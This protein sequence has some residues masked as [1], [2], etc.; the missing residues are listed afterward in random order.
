V[1]IGEMVDTNLQTEVRNLYVCDASTFPEALD[2][3]TVLTIIGLGKRLSDHLLTTVFRRGAKTRREPVAP[4]P[5]RVAPEPLSVF[6][7]PTPS[8]AC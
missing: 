5:E 7:P 4:E 6:E 2:R 3:P 1:R 8:P